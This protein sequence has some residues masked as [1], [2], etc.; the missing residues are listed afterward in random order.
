MLLFPFFLDFIYSLLFS[1]MHF[2]WFSA[3]EICNEVNEIENWDQG[4]N[5]E[6][7]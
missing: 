1:K 3:E 7:K 4:K 5:K 2:T 6:R